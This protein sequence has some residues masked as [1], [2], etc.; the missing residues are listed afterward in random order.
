MKGAQE[1]LFDVNAASKTTVGKLDELQLPDQRMVLPYMGLG[2]GAG[3][4]LEQM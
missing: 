1:H 2:R 3:E 4:V